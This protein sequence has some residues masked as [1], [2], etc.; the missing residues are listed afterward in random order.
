MPSGCGGGGETELL[1][2]M[3][4]PHGVWYCWKGILKWSPVIEFICGCG[5]G[6]E[7]FFPLDP[8]PSHHPKSLHLIGVSI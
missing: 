5:E 7:K 3:P 4:V 6:K 2:T 1:F 8:A